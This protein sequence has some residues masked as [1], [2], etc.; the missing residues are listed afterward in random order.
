[1]FGRR[2]NKI[3]EQIKEAAAQVKQYRDDFETHMS[4][5]KESE[6]QMKEDLS[7][8]MENTISMTEY[9]V[10][11]VEK[12]TS[13]LHSMDR[14]TEEVQTAM[15]D[16]QQIVELVKENYEAV[17]NLV[18]NNKHYTTSSKHL[19]E[20]PGKIKQQYHSYEERTEKLAECAR[21]MSVQAI[22]TAV[23]AGRLGESGKKFVAASEELRQMALD[24]EKSALCMKEELEISQKKIQELEE[25]SL[26]LIALIKE[27]NVGTTR[28][29]KKYMALHK[30]VERSSMRDFSDD[31]IVM[32]DKVV[33][34]RNLE[35]EMIKVGERNKIQL[36]DIQ[37]E[38]QIQQ[39]E[40]SELESDLTYMFDDALERFIRKDLVLFD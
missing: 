9:A 15:K 32:R 38:L 13:L 19:T 17:T 16:Y 2:K 26:R 36:N 35:E 5:T 10:Q 40:L 1:M 8:V 3:K 7:Q 30:E 34:M 25:Y 22:N 14:F 23:E 12:E 31:V 28:L 33:S 4:S 6:K 11:N 37:E 29:M 18:D 39:Q 24:C 20:I 21:E 27:G